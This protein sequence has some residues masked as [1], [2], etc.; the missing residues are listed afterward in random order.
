MSYRRKTGEDGEFRFAIVPP[1]AYEL[2]LTAEGFLNK[3]LALTLASGDSRSLKILLAV[4]PVPDM[5]YCGPHP[6]IHYDPPNSNGRRVEGIVRDYLDSKPIPKAEIILLRAGEKRPVAVSTADSA[7]KFKFIDPP[8]GRYTLRV[9]RSGYRQTDLKQFLIP[10]ENGTF[11]DFP[12]LK[13][14]TM[15]VCE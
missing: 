3:N 12:I 8:A 13:R 5:N 1:G 6:L 11:V 7:G 14:K 15:I 9:S 10:R 2:G 4:A